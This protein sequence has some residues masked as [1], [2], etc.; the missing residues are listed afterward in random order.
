MKNN[1]SIQIKNNKYQ[2]NVNINS[3]PLEMQVG[4]N[5][6]AD[7]KLNQNDL[8]FN[9]EVT[10]LK[11]TSD[12]TF[13]FEQGEASDTWNISHNLDKYPSVTV[14]DTAGTQF[15]VEVNYIDKNNITLHMNGATKGI[16]YLN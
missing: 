14:V 3:N 15:Y 7:F 16:V 5:Y 6:Q 12:K 8:D 13:V 2:A 1:N 4:R 11:F 9:G 10:T